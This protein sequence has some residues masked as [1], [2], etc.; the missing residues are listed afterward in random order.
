MIRRFGEVIE[1]AV[2]LPDRRIAVARAEHGEVLRAVE[3]A[4]RLDIASSIL[5]GDADAVRR[6]LLAAGL[7]PAHYE[8]VHAPTPEEAAVTAVRLVA[9]GQADTL[10]KGMLDTNVLLHAVLDHDH[11]LRAGRILSHVGL[12]ETDRYPK[13]LAITDGG[14]VIHP[15]LDT[16]EQ[17]LR[18]ALDVTRALGVETAKV[19]VI[20]AKEK[21]TP[22][23][24]ATMDAAALATRPIPGA[25]VAGPLAVDNAIDP[26]SAALKGITHPVAGDADVLL[27]P[28]IESGNVCYKTL[29]FLGRAQGA[30][31]VV[32]GRRPMVV[33]SRADDELARLNS[34]A[35]AVLVGAAQAAADAAAPPA[36]GADR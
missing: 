22:R 2:S 25:L 1:R 5:V 24:P 18:N 28:C 15:D 12:V 17:I 35:L 9:E 19:A 4:R 10:M 3:D 36:T 23:M 31:L 6:E 16:K 30:G 34:I 29:M 8:I 32:G 27:M 33:T 13:L 20:A 26:A 21:A 11:G 7:Q 14:L